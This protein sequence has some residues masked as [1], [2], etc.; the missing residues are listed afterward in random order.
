M[1]VKKGD[2]VK[3]ITGKDKGKEGVV[4]T[5]FPKNDRVIVEGVNMVKKHQKPSATV[6]QG[7]IV[8]QEA[9]IHVSNVMVVD[10]STNEPT[11]VGYKVVD[12]KKVRVSKKTGEVLD[13]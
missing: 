8:E 12:G 9:S 10:P 11:R 7:G 4:L 5:A 13:K 6:P 2:K 3:I 1:F